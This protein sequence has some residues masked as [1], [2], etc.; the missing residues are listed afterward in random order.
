MIEFKQN[1]KESERAY[2]EILRCEEIGR[3][4]RLIKN[5][6]TKMYTLLTGNEIEAYDFDPEKHKIIVNS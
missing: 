3:K 2:D 5:R 6:E 4:Y 1:A